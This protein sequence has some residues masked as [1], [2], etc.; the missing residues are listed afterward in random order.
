MSEILT[1]R[2][3]VKLL[4][5][6]RKE[7]NIAADSAI[8]EQIKALRDVIIEYLGLDGEIEEWS[9]YVTIAESDCIKIRAALEQT[10]PKEG[11]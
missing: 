10:K 8:N 4:L 7:A 2:E 3:Q 1:L 5:E 9:G 11:E 6:T